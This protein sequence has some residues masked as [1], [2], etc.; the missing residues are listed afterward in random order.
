MHYI[1][2][3]IKRFGNDTVVCIITS[4]TKSYEQKAFFDMW[5]LH[6][7]GIMMLRCKGDY[8]KG[9]LLAAIPMR[10]CLFFPLQ[11]RFNEI[12]GQYNMSLDV[13]NENVEQKNVESFTRIRH[14]VKET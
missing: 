11:N 3:R 1:D 9:S 5:C 13:V 6:A 8:T 4:L 2:A 14:F 12:I 10:G 7:M